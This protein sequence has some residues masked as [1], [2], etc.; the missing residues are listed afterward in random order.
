[1]WNGSF[2]PDLQKR[3]LDVSFDPENTDDLD[4]RPPEQIIGIMTVML[5]GKP[6]KWEVTYAEFLAFQ[7]AGFSS[8]Y[9]NANF[10]ITYIGDWGWPWGRVHNVGYHPTY[11]FY[12]KT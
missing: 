9:L 1:M 8:S 2:S 11:G 10:P 4:S 3:A 7:K 5:N 6:Y 12:T